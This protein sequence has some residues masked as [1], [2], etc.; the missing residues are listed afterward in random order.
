MQQESLFRSSNPAFAQLPY[1]YPDAVQGDYVP[2]FQFRGGRTR[3][4]RPV[5]DRPR[6]VHQREHDPRRGRQPDQGGRLA[7]AQGRLL[8]PE[9]LQAAEHLRQLQRQ[10]QLPGQHQQP[11]RH[12]LRLRQ[13]GHR[14][15]QH[16]H[17]G[18]EVRHSG[19]ALQ[20]RRVLRA[21][22]LEGGQQADARLRR[23]LLLPDAAVGRDAAGV[24]LPARA[25]SPQQRGAALRAGLHRRL[26]LLAAQ[27][28][29]HGSG[30]RSRRASRR[31]WPTRS[32]IA[33]SAG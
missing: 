9:Q 22:Q 8:L 33:S 20:E 21:G 4:R 17:A 32:R 30:A 11:V 24:E 18:L 27:P 12:R 29:R 23:A 5:P 31:R 28:P 15:L 26:S 10:D 2:E 6:A 16:L 3:Q 25:S 7:R 1:F 13:R 19:M 14:R